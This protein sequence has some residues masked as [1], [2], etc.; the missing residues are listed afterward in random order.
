MLR[1][2][3]QTYQSKHIYNKDQRGKTLWDWMTLLIVPAGLAAVAIL[4]NNFQRSN[5][6][7]RVTD[8]RREEALQNYLD[9]MSELLLE[10]S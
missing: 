10:K 8:Q 9:K 7:I 5:E 3:V 6:Q 2:L 1:V 4:F